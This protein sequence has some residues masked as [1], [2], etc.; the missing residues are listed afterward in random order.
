MGWSA[1]GGVI[2]FLSFG[3]FSFTRGF[4]VGSAL[5]FLAATIRVAIIGTSNGPDWA[6]ICRERKPN[7]SHASNNF[8]EVADNF[9]D[10]EAVI[11]LARWYAD[12]RFSRIR[13]DYTCLYSSLFIVFSIIATKAGALTLSLESR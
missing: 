4:R 2:L 6:A 13:L 7:P 3:F 12:V 8:L 9:L 5:T 11:C 1:S 10:F